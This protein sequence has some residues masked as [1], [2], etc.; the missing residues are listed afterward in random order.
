MVNERAA[1]ADDV[2]DDVDAQRLADLL[3]RLRPRFAGN[4]GEDGEAALAREVEGRK[5]LSVLVLDPHMRDARARPGRRLVVQLGVEFEGRLHLPVGHG[6]VGAV[7]TPCAS[8]SYFLK[9]MALRMALRCRSAVGEASQRAVMLAWIF[10]TSAPPVMPK[11]ADR[12]VG[13]DAD[14]PGDRRA[15]DRTGVEKR[16]AGLPLEHGRQLPGE[17]EA[18]LDGGIRAEPVGG[19]AD[20]RR[21]P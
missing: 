10:S 20:G 8:N 18:V 14:L 9:A 4:A 1:R 3:R 15:L 17:V 16:R 7:S 13:A 12:L 5:L 6:R 11:P 2:S 21:R 19:E